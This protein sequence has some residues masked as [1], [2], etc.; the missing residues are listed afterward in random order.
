MAE[1]Q[2]TPPKPS[3]RQIEGVDSDDDTAA[4]T[5]QDDIIVNKPEDSDPDTEKQGENSQTNASEQTE[6]DRSKIDQERNG[7]GDDNNQSV[8]EL[9]MHKN[10]DSNLGE[11]MQAEIE[12]RKYEHFESSQLE[13]GRNGKTGQGKNDQMGKEQ[14][15]RNHGRAELEHEKGGPVVQAAEDE[16]AYLAYVNTPCEPYNLRSTSDQL[17]HVQVR[18]T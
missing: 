6:D 5:S 16:E 15:Q 3:R 1:C 10:A 9:R 18:S 13:D 12:Q 17:T 7:N 14:I 4:S 2:D 11:N 8:Q